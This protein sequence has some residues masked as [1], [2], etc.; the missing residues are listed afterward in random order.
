MLT[1]QS[2]RVDYGK[3][4]ALNIR[5]PLHFARG[6]RVGILGS[7]GAGK[8]TLL[9]A[10]LGLTPYRGSVQS[11]VKPEE[12]AVHMQHNMYVD[13]MNT[14]SVIEGL[15]NTRIKGNSK[16]A[17][18]IEFFEFE[19]NLRKKFKHLSGGQKNR[20]T[21]LLVMYQDRPLTFFDEVTSGLDFETRTKLMEKLNEY[22]ANKDATLLLV[23]HY[24][25]ELENLVDKILLLDKGEVV[26]HGPIEE[27]FRQYCGKS[28]IR[29]Q[30]NEK[31]LEVTEEFKQIFAPPG[32]IAL[33][34]D[35]H[36]DEV[37]ILKVLS[38]EN[39]DFTRSS[40]DI[41]LITI[42]ARRS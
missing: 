39:I 20:M 9:K 33:R 41:E 24:Y 22:Y 12:I 19:P 17:E 14:Q 4:T 21:L 42:N 15:L 11:M 1:I 5:E 6:E 37:K 28:V 30:K 29:M 34:M 25:E 2:M 26:C 10:L 23:S 8:S 36:E 38:N 32:E 13:T 31:N 40:K 3:L 16:L 7:N 27:L 18:L 35:T